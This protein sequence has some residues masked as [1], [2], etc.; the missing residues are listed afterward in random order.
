MKKILPLYVFIDACG[1]EIIKN[2]SFGKR[3][4]PLRRRLESVFGYS[5]GCIPSILSGRWPE[6]HRN[7]SYFVYDPAN[8][9]FQSLK[10]LKWLPKAITSRRRFR[11]LLSKFLKG[12]LKFRGYFDLYNI[13]FEYI[14]L[15]DFSEKKNPLQ[16]NG[17]NSGLN[18]FDYLELFDVPYHVSNPKVSEYENLETAL[19]EIES[20]RLDFA[21]IYWPDLDGLMHKEGNQSAQIDVKLD[22][23]EQWINRLMAKSYEHYEEVRLYVFSDHG[24]ANCSSFLNLKQKIDTLDQFKMGRDYAVVYDS[25]MARFWFFNE[26]ARVL[27]TQCLDQIPEGHILSDLELEKMRVRF[28]DHYFGELIF[29]VKE[30]TLIVPSD[31]GQKPL[32]G[33]HGYHPSDIHSYAMMMTNQDEISDDVVSIP[34]IFDLMKKDIEYIK[35]IDNISDSEPVLTL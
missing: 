9:P 33:M 31:M 19:S 5:S 35:D 27:I 4:A 8:S 10:Y 34:H 1:W 23:Y 20:E 32:R 25:T 26:N 11:Y 22:L 24:M 21:F 16:P 18:I 28:S 12:P 14:S 7:W 6:S 3:F 15:F 13:P 29:L 17:L 30:G 2:R